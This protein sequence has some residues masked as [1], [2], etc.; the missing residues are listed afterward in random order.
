MDWLWITLIV[1]GIIAFLYSFRVSQKY[2]V[3]FEGTLPNGTIITSAIAAGFVWFVTLVLDGVR[4][5]WAEIGPIK[6]PPVTQEEIPFDPN[7]PLDL[8][9]ALRANMTENINK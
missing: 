3:F 9:T 1:Y 7:Q 5:V 6:T 4:G 2:F 8:Q